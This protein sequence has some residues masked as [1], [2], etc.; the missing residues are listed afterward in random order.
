MIL[1]RLLHFEVF[2]NSFCKAFRSFR[3]KSF[4]SGHFIR[5]VCARNY[6]QLSHQLL[7][8]HWM[9]FEFYAMMLFKIS[10]RYF[11]NSFTNG[12]SAKLSKPCSILLQLLRML[13]HHYR[14]P[15]K[16]WDQHSYLYFFKWR[17]C[18]NPW[19]HLSFEIL[20]QL[21][22]NIYH[23]RLVW[24]LGFQGFKLSKISPKLHLKH[25]KYSIWCL[26]LNEMLFW[27]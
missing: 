9:D 2:A 10:F 5:L 4:V 11:W 8:S 22:L 6:S 27:F 18:L 16:R 15:H 23:W 17:I 21:D 1:N 14:I 19:I 7:I 3:L 26:Y 20:F 12:L 13:N 25:L 24:S